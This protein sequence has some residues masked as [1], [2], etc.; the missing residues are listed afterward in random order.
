MQS[1]DECRD[2]MIMCILYPPPFFIIIRGV[3]ALWVLNR[4]LVVLG[5]RLED[6]GVL[7]GE[8]IGLEE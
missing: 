5:G 6:E 4:V 2:D 3:L 8:G 1:A 7:D